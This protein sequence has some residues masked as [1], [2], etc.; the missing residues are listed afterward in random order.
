MGG[1]A[2]RQ[3]GQPLVVPGKGPAGSIHDQAMDQDFDLNQGRGRGGT[4]QQS[5]PLQRIAREP[6]I[7]MSQ[8]MDKLRQ[9]HGQMAVLLDALERQLAVFKAGETPDYG[10]IHSILDYFLTYPDLCH[11]PKED[12]VALRLRRR[13]PARAGKL[14]ELLSGHDELALLSRRFA[15]ATVDQIL[16]GDE[17]PREWFASFGRNFVE[18]NRRHMAR[19]EEF[20]FPLALEVLRDEDWAAIE[21]QLNDRDDPL[22][23]ETVETRFQK[24]RDTIIGPQQPGQPQVPIL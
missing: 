16:G 9:E 8:I 1:V 11:H 18:V 4:A 20:F 21:E 6:T 15:R 3:P 17:V 22:F 7:T 24:L 12:L 19:E 14:T 10:Q 13:D 5:N 23:G 2:F